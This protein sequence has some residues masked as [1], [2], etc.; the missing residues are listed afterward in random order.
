VIIN[1]L[2]NLEHVAIRAIDCI[3][4]SPAVAST[5]AHPANKIRT[6]KLGDTNSSNP[7]NIQEYTAVSDVQLEWLLEPPIA[8]GTL[9]ELDIAIVVD[10]GVGGGW[11]GGIPGGPG[12]GFGANGNAPPFASS[13]FADLLIRCGANLEK[14]VLQD[15]SEGGGVSSFRYALYW[16]SEADLLTCNQLNPNF[17]APPH[18]QYPF[19]FPFFSSEHSLTR[20]LHYSQTQTSIALSARSQG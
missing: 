19:L 5:N 9:K 14:L 11:P 15:L 20:S 10:P 12:G 1:G 8:N 4:G 13:T 18:S 17:V 2:P 6:F 3:S 16:I 7:Y